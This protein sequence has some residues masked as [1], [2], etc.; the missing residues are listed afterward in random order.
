MYHASACHGFTST[1]ASSPPASVSA[2]AKPTVAELKT[3]LKARGLTTT[4]LKV[5]ALGLTLTLDLTLTLTLTLALTLALTPTLTLP[6]TCGLKA[7]LLARLAAT[8]TAPG[9]SPQPAGAVSSALTPTP[10]QP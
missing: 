2:S 3:E 10:T 9:L 4:G 7:E 1:S 6:L 8:S 5:L